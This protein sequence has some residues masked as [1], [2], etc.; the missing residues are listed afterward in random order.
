MEVMRRSG[1]GDAS[2][3]CDLAQAK[4]SWARGLDRFKSSVE[5]SASKIAVVIRTLRAVLC[6]HAALIV[7]LDVDKFVR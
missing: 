3:P 1:V 6:R 2:A 7:Q 4:S 5:H